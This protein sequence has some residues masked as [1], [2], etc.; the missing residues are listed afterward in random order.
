MEEVNRKAEIR[1]LF[2][3]PKIGS[4]SLATGFRMNFL[5]FS[6][7]KLHKNYQMSD[8]INS[9]ICLMLSVYKCFHQMVKYG[10][11]RNHVLQG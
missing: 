3:K 10:H 11:Q 8:K 4:I 2:K 5:S 9:H 6:P 7:K 1:L